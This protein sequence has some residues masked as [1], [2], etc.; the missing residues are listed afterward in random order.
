[1]VRLMGGVIQRGEDVFTL[2]EW[3]VLQNLVERSSC[4]EKFQHVRNADALPANAR[5]AA[6]LFG[7]DGN[8][9]E[10]LVIHGMSSNFDD[11][12]SPVQR[13]APWRAAA[14]SRLAI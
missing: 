14:P 5:A 7:F 13:Q 8:P 3:I 10:A 11:T 2:K 12:Q 4:G 1:V 6:A 9:I